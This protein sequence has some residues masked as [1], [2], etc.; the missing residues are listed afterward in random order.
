MGLDDLINKGKQALAG[1]DGKVDYKEYSK[2]AQEA[3]KDYNST[4]GDFQTKAKAVYT[5][6]QDDHKKAASG[7]AKK[8]AKDDVKET[9]A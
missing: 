8:E 3:Y 7:D 5:G 1:K 6:Y 4:E 9:K 2:D